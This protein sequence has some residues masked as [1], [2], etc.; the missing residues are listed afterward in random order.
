MSRIRGQTPMEEGELAAAPEGDLRPFVVFTQLRQGGPYLYAGW[1]DAADAAMALDF[2]REHYGRDQECVGLWVIRRGALAS[3]EP[4]YPAPD[5]QGARRS[6]Q[7]FAYREGSAAYESAG[8]VEARSSQEALDATVGR[9]DGDRI[10][11]ADRSAIVATQPG[12]VIWRLTDQSYRMARGYSKDV[13]EKWER[14][15]RERDIEEY[16][17]EDLKEAF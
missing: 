13:R 5:D 2:A 3:S 10:W 6:F 14:I 7:V 16:E 9:G 1:L 4:L 12:E 15:R 17:K 11:V 8:E